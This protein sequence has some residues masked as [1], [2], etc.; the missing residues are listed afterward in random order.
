MIAI[1]EKS[2]V[3]GGVFMCLA[4]QTLAQT[5]EHRFPVTEAMVVSALADRQVPVQGLE[6]RIAAPITSAAAI[7]VLDIQS[8]AANTSH[9]AR[10][11]FACHVRHECMPF[12]ATVNWPQRVDVNQLV[13]GLNRFQT[14]NAPMAAAAARKT[15]PPAAEAAS[16]EMPAGTSAVLVIEDAR[17]HVTLRVISLES[18]ST[19][20]L[21]H[22]A[23]PDHKQ[24]FVAAVVNSGL[25]RGQF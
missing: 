21:I 18:G 1:P 10:I 16:A 7:P 14:E 19:G 9:S 12:Y 2:L 25:L 13:I 6:V 20:D 4:V 15:L 8:V 22:V 23:T 5:P 3:A 17:V 11:R 24:R